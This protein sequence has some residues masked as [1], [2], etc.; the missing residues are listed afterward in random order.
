MLSVLVK[1]NLNT[2]Y[3]LKLTIMLNSTHL[4]CTSPQTCKISK[5]YALSFKALMSLVILFTLLTTN[6]V[7]AQTIGESK[8]SCDI[9]NRNP[10]TSKDLEI[11]RVFIGGDN[12]Q[13]C[14]S[15]TTVKYPLYMTIHNGTKSERTSFALY[16]N[17]SSG[18]TINGQGG[19]IFVCV[20]PIDI[21]SD[22]DRGD[23]LGNQTFYVGEIEFACGQD[24]ELTNNFLA[25]TDASGTTADRCNTFSAATKCSDIAPK[26][27]TDDNITIV[28]PLVAP[29]L[30]GDDPTCTVS[31]GKL[32][33]TSPTSGLL[34]SLDGG[35]FAAYPNGGWNVAPGEH[36]VRAKNTDCTSDPTCITIGG[37][38]ANPDRPVVTLQDASVCGSLT[39]P[40]VTVTCPIAGT[41]TL[42]QTGVS[43]S[44]TKTYP[45]DKTPDNTIVFS[46]QAG[47][48][49]SIT[50]TNT[51]G[52]TSEATTCTNYQS[53]SCPAPPSGITKADVQTIELVAPK[54]KV[55]AAPNPFTNRVRF[56]LNSAVS[57]MGS[58]EIFNTMGQKIATV[59]QGYVEAGKPLNKEYVA[60]RA[61]RANLIYVFRVGD[62]K[63]TGKLLNW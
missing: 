53:N 63:T 16:G 39:A 7:I 6:S 24:L 54:T 51:D 2:F 33:V 21:K 9:S 56:T 20:G 17:L 1:P 34:F 44:Q 58:L 50:V 40:T 11:V 26:C 31:T 5:L 48:G 27:G 43:G 52:C 62:Q 59:Y 25:W 45:T 60:Q 41:Y 55:L 36:C 49:F 15:N 10:C 13:G 3:N 46:V 18:A 8:L 4:N 22:E 42:T 14:V 28:G 32:T 38:P 29:T 30:D 19:K 35:D 61:L 12:C 57:G 23:G 47:K 37:A